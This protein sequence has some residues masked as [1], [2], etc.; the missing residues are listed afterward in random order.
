MQWHALLWVG[1]GGFL[2]A[3]ARYIL[4][5]WIATRFPPVL[6]KAMPLGTAF[7]NITG[8]FLLALFLAYIDRRLNMP[9]SVKLLV[10]TGF[11]GAYTTFS[12]YA[13]EGFALLNSKDW[14]VGLIYI[15]GTNILCLLGV[16]LGLFIANRLF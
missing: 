3:N 14:L 10:G 16:M 13:N 11:F 12:T 15:F 7:V 2:G 6:G 4:S 9:D 8:S 1:I 5:S